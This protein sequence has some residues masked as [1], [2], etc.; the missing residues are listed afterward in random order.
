MKV[1]K[2]ATNNIAEC[3]LVEQQKG[4]CCE[5]KRVLVM[6]VTVDGEDLARKFSE[7]QKS[8]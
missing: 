1:L 6:F 7:G 8:V 5:W 2:L 3:V 4:E